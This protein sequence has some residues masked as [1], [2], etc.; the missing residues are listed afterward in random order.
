[1][2]IESGFAQV[3]QSLLWPV[4]VLV[5]LAFVYALWAGGATLMEAWQR[6]RQPQYRSL[7]VAPGLS[8][9]ELELQLV[10][11]VEP[12]RLLSRLSPMLGLIATMIPLGPA[13]QNVA[14][15]NGQQALAVFSGA[16]A[17]VVLA[18]AAAS[19]GLVVYSV[20]RRWLLAELLV[21]R[22]ERGVAQ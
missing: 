11:Q 18:L 1:M 2:N 4:L 9:E 7:R 14:A 6:W 19:V 16:F 5:G 22:K 13:L 3:A 8:M 12:V 15:G 10:R 21:V 20:R 17:G